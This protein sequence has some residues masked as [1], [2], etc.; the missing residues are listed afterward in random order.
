MHIVIKQ[1]INH[2][3]VLILLATVLSITITGCSS[4][5]STTEFE[6]GTIEEMINNHSFIF[7]AEKMYPLREKT[8]VLTSLLYDVYVNN[9]SLVSFLPYSG[10]FFFGKADPSKVSTQFTSTNF[11]YEVKAVKNNQWQVILTPKDAPT[12]QK[13]S[14]TIFDNGSASVSVSST[15]M[16]Q[17]S[18]DG[19]LKKI[20]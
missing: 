12:I 9:D 14:F 7:M 18:Y 4:S 20:E 13:L 1:K 8:V 10:Q 3:S 15:S 2:Y 6:K 19:Y 16:D 5:K 17:I 11:T